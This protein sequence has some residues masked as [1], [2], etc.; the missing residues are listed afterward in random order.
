M[1]HKNQQFFQSLKHNST[2]FASFTQPNSSLSNHP[3]TQ[4]FS[5]IFLFFPLALLRARFCFV[6][7]FL[8]TSSSSNFFATSFHLD[9]FPSTVLPLTDSH[10]LIFFHQF[11]RCQPIIQTFLLIEKK[12][13][14]E[15][16]CFL[17]LTQSPYL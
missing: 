10:F 17:F 5:L 2:P 12:F 1:T 6:F 16:N 9:F 11:D 4:R 13:V 3:Y 7:N 15:E 8:C 14:E